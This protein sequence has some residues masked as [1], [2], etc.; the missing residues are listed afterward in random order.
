MIFINLWPLISVNTNGVKWE[1]QDT[2][3]YQVPAGDV[4]C[5]DIQ[6]NIQVSLMQELQDS[7]DFKASITFVMQ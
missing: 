7:P 4:K 3:M 1:R 2:V 6:D 5:V